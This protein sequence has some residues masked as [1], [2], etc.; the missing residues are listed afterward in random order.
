[1]SKMIALL[2]L[3]ILPFLSSCSNTTIVQVDPALVVPCE[4]SEITGKTW[5]DLAIAYVE[6]GNDLDT[7]NQRL[8]VI[9]DSQ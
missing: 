4:K 2:S 9:R 6:R 7:C 1:M 8:K 5:R 3:S